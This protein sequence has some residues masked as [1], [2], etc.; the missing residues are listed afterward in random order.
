[1]TPEEIPEYAGKVAA[2]KG[3]LDESVY[4][5]AW[6]EGHRMTMEQAMA[7]ANRKMRA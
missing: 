5:T 6:V 2:L 7:Y 4:Q 3:A 1:M